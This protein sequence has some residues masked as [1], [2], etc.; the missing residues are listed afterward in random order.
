MG[1]DGL[2]AGKTKIKYKSIDLGTVVSVELTD[3]LEGVVA[4]A[5]LDKEASRYLNE[6][7][8][9][10]V[11]RPEIGAGGVTGLDEADMWQD[12]R[13][14]IMYNWIYVCVVA[15]TL[16]ASN[17]TAFAWM[18]QMVARHSAASDDLNVFELM[19]G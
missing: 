10:W 4:T 17:E 7:T 19:P 14:G 11:V 9:F 2:T 13:R 12:Y 3:D 6:E 1:G 15:G 16:D 8:I 18:A 5:E